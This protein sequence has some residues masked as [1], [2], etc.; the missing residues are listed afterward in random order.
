MDESPPNMETKMLKYKSGKWMSA[1]F[2]N[3]ETSK[4]LFQSWVKSRSQWH[5][6]VILP[7]KAAEWGF[8]FLTTSVHKF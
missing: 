1:L 8:E 6:G 7:L 5:M 3:Q 4:T 2:K